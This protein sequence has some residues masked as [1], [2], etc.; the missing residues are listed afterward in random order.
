M[1]E[2]IQTK[3]TL[4]RL[5]PTPPTPPSAPLTAEQLRERIKLGGKVCSELRN[6]YFNGKAWIDCHTEVSKMFTE[7]KFRARKLFKEMDE[8]DMLFMLTNYSKEDFVDIFS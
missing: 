5:P 2:E 8:R 3:E 1:E 4:K 6:I 7:L